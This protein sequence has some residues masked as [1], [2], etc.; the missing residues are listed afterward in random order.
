MGMYGG[1]QMGFAIDAACGCHIGKIRRNNEDNFYFDG[2]HLEAN[3]SGL[4]CPLHIRK[5]LTWEWSAAIFDGMGGEN[6]GELASYAAARKMA[7][8]GPNWK[9]WFR[10]FDVHI[11]KQT[12]EPNRAVL[13]A[14]EEMKTCHM[15]TTMVSISIVRDTVY[16]CN[17]GDSRAYWFHDGELTQ[18]SVDHVSSRPQHPERKAPLTQHL[19]IDPED[20]TLEPHIAKRKYVGGDWYLLC[21]DGLSDMLTDQ[22][23]A[24][25]MRSHGKTDACVQQLI[26]A[27][28]ENGGRDNITV[29]VVRLD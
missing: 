17:V 24:G 27:A 13:D 6:F 28:L 11:R 18:L 8:T 1:I 14:Q 7:A 25:I 12:E 20:L 23:I 29:I 3:N 5:G 19:G 2:K 16:L 26:Q 15:G 21:T 9:R 22:Q 4:T 10:P